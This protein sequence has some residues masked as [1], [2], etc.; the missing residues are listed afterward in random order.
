MTTV[1]MMDQVEVGLGLTLVLHPN[2]QVLQGCSE[3]VDLGSASSDWWQQSLSVKAQLSGPHKP[4]TTVCL[5]R[6]RPW[7]SEENTF[8][9]RG[10]HDATLIPSR[11]L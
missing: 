3:P 4:G 10:S 2:P 7:F 11:H 9:R 5:C 1:L 6:H 8:C